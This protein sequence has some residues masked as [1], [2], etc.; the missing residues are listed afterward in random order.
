[1][2]FLMDFSHRP[3][4]ASTL[5]PCR[6]T[7]QNGR[8]AL[9]ALGL[10]LFL[11]GQSLF[12]QGSLTPPGA[13]A[14]T[15][16]TLA[17]IE[18]RTAIT[19]SGPVT[20]SRP[21]SY[22][23]TTNITVSFSTGI[24]IA[25][26]NV[27]LDL[28]GFSIFTTDP[29]PGSTG[30]YINN[31]MHDIHMF[32]GHITGGITNNG[33]VFNGPGFYYGV[34]HAGNS[35]NVRASSIT[36]S[37]CLYHGIMLGVGI[38]SMIE[39]CQ[40]DTVG[41]YGL[42]ATTIRDS[43]ASG[44]GQS[45]M[46]GYTILNCF[47]SSGSGDPALSGL[48]VENCYA[49]STA[50]DAISAQNALNCNGYCSG[51]GRALTAASASNCKGYS[52]ANT[53]LFGTVLHN[54]AG[55]GGGTGAGILGILAQNCYGNATGSGPGINATVVNNCYAVSVSGSAITGNIVTGSY[56][57]SSSGT[58]INTTIAN[59]SLGYGSPGVSA[60]FKYNMP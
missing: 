44:C 60:S 22:Y 31:T 18:P 45:G 29:S 17:Q 6:L 28:N 58:G 32:N 53:A 26:N 51:S 59:S 21:G 37:G 24:T 42:W 16:K 54:C 5:F 23:L 10:V 7:A 52:A 15:M 20:I 3:L 30:I 35:R 50:G 43:S 46:Y 38:N 8:V 55:Q 13:P 40:V 4:S 41:G 47:S 11:S 9:C 33:G 2:L 48:T 19:N 12:S 1:M 14:P 39:S 34:Y 36:V 25:T 56:G 57:S 27:T 49:T